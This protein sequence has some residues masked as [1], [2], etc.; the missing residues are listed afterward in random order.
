MPA[1]A[2]FVVFI[3]IMMIVGGTMSTIFSKMVGQEVNMERVSGL[4]KN[5]NMT[6]ETVKT[7]FRHPL[8]LN[9]LMF[10]GEASLLV[11]LSF[12]LRN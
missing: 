9:L 10:T 1:S 2:S 5:G 3:N 11:I 7:E 12:Q 8:F 6:Y 4:D